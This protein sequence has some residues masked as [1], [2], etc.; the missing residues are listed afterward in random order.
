[1]A[2]KHAPDRKPYSQWTPHSCGPSLPFLVPPALQSP[3]MRKRSPCTKR[4]WFRHHRC[5]DSRSHPGRGIALCNGTRTVHR[6]RRA[7]TA[8]S[9][10]SGAV[11]EVFG[12]RSPILNR[13][14]LCV[15]S[16]ISPG[17]RDIPGLESCRAGSHVALPPCRARDPQI[18][19]TSWTINAARIT[20]RWRLLNLNMPSPKF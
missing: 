12:F 3:T 20:M 13:W 19:P 7:G 16:I 11:D 4:R 1:M 9:V 14:T 10:E 6:L 18:C 15:S 5:L 17:V 8:E 2:K